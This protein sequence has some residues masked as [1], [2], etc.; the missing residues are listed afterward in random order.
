M[1]VVTT[2]MT[3]NGDRAQTPA[4]EPQ[5]DRDS[6]PRLM[7][8]VSLSPY[9]VRCVLATGFDMSNRGDGHHMGHPQAMGTLRYMTNS[10]PVRV[11]ILSGHLS[12]PGRGA[13][14]SAGVYPDT[15]A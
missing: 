2:P 8:W 1:A 12:V 4:A 11:S 13:D 14:A 3:E 9:R 10:H 5:Y 6:I 7:T 15:R